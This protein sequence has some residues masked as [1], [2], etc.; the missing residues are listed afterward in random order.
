MGELTHLLSSS[1]L[2]VLTL[3]CFCCPPGSDSAQGSDVSLT[4]DPRG[5]TLEGLDGRGV[6]AEGVPWVTGI[7]EGDI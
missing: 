4:K 1:L 7:F 2:G 3:S 6:G 5:E